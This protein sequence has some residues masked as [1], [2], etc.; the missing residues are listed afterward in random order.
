MDEHRRGQSSASPPMDDNP[1]G[2]PSSMEDNRSWMYKERKGKLFSETW[3]NGLENFLDHA[4]A[5]PEAAVDEESPCTKCCCCH[6]CKRDE[7]TIHL[8]SNGFQLGYE[9]WTSHGEPNTLENTEE[10]DFSVHADRMNEM[11]V[12]AIAAEGVFP[13]EEL[14]HAAKEFYR[15]LVEADTPLH[16]KTS[17]TCLSMVGRLMNIKTRYNLSEA[18]HNETMTLIHDVVGDA[19]AEHLPVNFHMSKKFERRRLENE[20]RHLRQDNKKMRCMEHV[21][22]TLASD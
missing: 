19:A 5:L 9:K 14:T 15:M 22:R 12:D 11:L 2:A 1:S 6:K 16:E 10:R 21:L 13:G 20:N 7:M 18:W 4:F 17:H 8:C 3:R